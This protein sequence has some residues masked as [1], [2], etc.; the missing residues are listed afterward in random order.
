MRLEHQLDA[1]DAF[2]SLTLQLNLV[3]NIFRFIYGLHSEIIK[4]FQP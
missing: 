1:L 3:L 4:L 2:Y